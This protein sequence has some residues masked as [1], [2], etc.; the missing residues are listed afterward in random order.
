MRSLS[1]AHFS[2]PY[3]IPWRLWN[4][5]NGC[6]IA[7]LDVVRYVPRDSETGAFGGNSNWRGPVWLPI[8]FLFIEALEKLHA[9]PDSTVNY[10][11][12]ATKIS[13]KLISIF[14]LRENQSR[15]E[16]GR[17]ALPMEQEEVL[18]YEYFNPETG[19]GHGASHQTGWTAL[20]ADLLCQP[21]SPPGPST[22]SPSNPHECTTS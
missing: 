2:A 1:A 5:A 16:H 8:N 6:T 3:S 22:S 17:D 9:I 18:F 15:P 14:A 19:V 13:R 7:Q 21:S 12:T 11:D 10:H 20:V 4:D